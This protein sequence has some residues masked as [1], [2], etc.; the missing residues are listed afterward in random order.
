MHKSIELHAEAVDGC[1]F[2]WK[3]IPRSQHVTP[4][5]RSPPFRAL[6]ILFVSVFFLDVLYVDIFSKF[7]RPL[8][9]NTVKYSAEYTNRRSTNIWF[10]WYFCKK[11]TNK[12]RVDI[13]G[14]HTS[15]V[16]LHTHLDRGWFGEGPRHGWPRCRRQRS[17]CC[18][19]VSWL[20]RGCCAWEA[21]FDSCCSSVFCRHW[22]RWGV[23]IAG[24]SCWSW[25]IIKFWLHARFL[26]GRI[27][28]NVSTSS[29]T[30]SMF[31]GFA[32][33]TILV[34]W[35]VHDTNCCEA[36]RTS[37]PVSVFSRTAFSLHVVFYCIPLLESFR[38]VRRGQFDFQNPPPLTGHSRFHC[39]RLRPF[40]R[41]MLTFAPWSMKSVFHCASL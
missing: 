38:N 16:G 19:C 8:R 21:P 2:E 24:L 34:V 40:M 23:L 32:H 9:F 29:W 6:G 33:H 31:Y 25:V 39:K 1:T 20:F 4:Q 13:V 14:R 15:L 28:V 7:I 27:R 11:Q 18:A 12:R 37:T 3:I 26:N 22:A 5:W 41:L 36:L 35:H 30:T 17:V 10:L